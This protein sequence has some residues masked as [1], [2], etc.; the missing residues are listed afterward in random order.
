MAAPLGDRTRLDATIDAAAAV[1][2]VA[3]EVGDRCGR[4]RVRRRRVRRPPPPPQRR[5]RRRARD[6]R[7]RAD[8][9]GLRLRARVP[10]RRRAASARSSSC[11]PTCSRK[12][13][14][15]RSS[16]RCPCSRAGTPSSIAGVA[17]PDLEQ[18]CTR[19]RGRP[20]T[21]TPPRSRSTCSTRGAGSPPSF[22]A[23]ARRRG[24]GP[25]RPAPERVRRRVPQGEGAG[26]A[27]DT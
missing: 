3:D 13:P 12:P 6:L 26:A 16:T 14:R 4:R 11:S 7:R 15:S 24:R 1:A 9:G 10:R 21:S 18:W 23:A 5:R 20:P 27:V 17:D 2:L 8:A 19:R 25:A 22:G